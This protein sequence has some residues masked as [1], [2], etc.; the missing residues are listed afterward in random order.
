MPF[1]HLPFT[2]FHT[3]Y[4]STQ[5]ENIVEGRAEGTAG[6]VQP[7]ETKHK[8]TVSAVFLPLETKTDILNP[9]KSQGRVLYVSEGTSSSDGYS[10]SDDSPTKEGR[11]LSRDGIQ[12]E[13]RK[14]KQI[15]LN[16][17][18]L[19]SNSTY[20]LCREQLDKPQGSPLGNVACQSVVGTSLSEKKSV[21]FKLEPIDNL[22]KPGYE[23]KDDEIQKH[24]VAKANWK[25]VFCR[26]ILM[27]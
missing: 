16:R 15:Q 19:S 25:K 26:G 4:H 23:R 20:N 10:K 21:Q 8:L 9:T 7:V 3:P 24:Q 27:T 14:T 6:C 13:N 22:S 1:S 2:S 12:I 11:R 17:K 18:K 5:T